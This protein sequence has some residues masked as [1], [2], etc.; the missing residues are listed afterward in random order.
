MSTPTETASPLFPRL[1]TVNEV[2]A[3]TRL[4]KGHLAQLRYR[5]EGPKFLKP[6]SQTVIY[7][8][9]DI[10]SWLESTVYASTADL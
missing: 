6:T 8:E 7:R 2:S 10:L 4:S 1:L 9:E 3:L 5:G